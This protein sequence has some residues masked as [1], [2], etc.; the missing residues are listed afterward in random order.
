MPAE[1]DPLHFVVKSGGQH[2][3]QASHP[4]LA[5]GLRAFREKVDALGTGRIQGKAIQD[6]FALPGYGW[7]KDAT[8][9][10]FAALFRAGEIQLHTADGVLT[11]VGPQAI[12][13]FKSSVSFNRVG[14]SV[15]D[16]RPPLDAIE[17]AARRLE[18]IFATEVLPLEDKI[19]AAVRQRIPPLMETVGSLP[20]RL[21]LLELP[22]EE[23]ARGLLQSCADVLKN[24]ASNATMLLGAKECEVPGDV[25]WA[26]AVT[27]CLDGGAEKEIRL[28]VQTLAS[29]NGLVE[30][31]PADATG[32]IGP[33]EETT[34]HEAL[35][36]ENFHERNA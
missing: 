5:E 32:L 15:R 27:S 2:R 14:L 30:L 28:A 17:R 3:V 13:T 1:K 9:Y 19:S 16:S 25:S 36:S 23:R 26:R 18:E 4:A 29:V 33:A 21:R 8:R 22:G 35:K 31:F 34:M 7:T 10:V 6:L 24:D 12:E 11:T 20:D